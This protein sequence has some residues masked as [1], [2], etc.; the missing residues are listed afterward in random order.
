MAMSLSISGSLLRAA[1]TIRRLALL[2]GQ[3]RTCGAV[4]WLPMEA[5]GEELEEDEP[6]EGG[7]FMPG[8]KEIFMEDGPPDEEPLGE[9]REEE[10]VGLPGGTGWALRI[11]PMRVAS[12]SAS[13]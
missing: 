7:G 3:R 4:T 5:W 6:M 1:E 2:S 9:G 8:G 10:G 12:S 11:A 13:A